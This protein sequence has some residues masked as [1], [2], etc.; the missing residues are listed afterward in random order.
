M[1]AAKE[2]FLKPRLL[3]QLA[4]MEL[5]AQTV[6]EGFMSGL[7]RSPF[8]GLSIEFAEYRQYQPGDEPRRIDWK[9]Y[10]RSDRFYVKE[11]EEET[12]LDAWIILD[13][14][15]SMG[16][17]TS[18]LSKWQYGGILAASLAYLLQK[19]K[20]GIGLVILDEAIRLEIQTRST[21]GHLIHV[22]G[23]LE[24]TVP[25]RKT[26]LAEVL[27][28]VAATRIKRRGMVILISDLLDDP[29]AVISGLSHLRFGGN[30][31]IVF[32][33]LDPAELSFDFK[34]PSLFVE[35]ET[36]QM[37]PALADQVQAGYLQAIRQFVATYAEEMGK[38][39]IAHSLV[40]TGKP[41]D[42]ALLA[43]LSRYTRKR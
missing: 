19:Q 6:V 12:N 10:A 21:R 40:D 8:R 35:P 4:T 29:E 2:R 24:K 11:F 20:D 32:Q 9:T 15:A 16:F 13:A 34:G 27:H 23:E 28:Q 5:R 38:A 36:G 30:N 14:S 18:G 43:F 26:S 25:A 37:V 1:P 33:T 31:V 39:N 22:I 17:G 7:H 42:E 41:L 3:T